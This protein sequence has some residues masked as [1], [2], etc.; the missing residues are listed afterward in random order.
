MT[1]SLRPAWI[2]KDHVQ[3]PTR[4]EVLGNP[5]RRAP[6]STHLVQALFVLRGRL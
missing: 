3:V 6:D 2:A 1:A 4:A 5:S